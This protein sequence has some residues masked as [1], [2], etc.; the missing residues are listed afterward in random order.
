MDPRGKVA[1]ITGGSSGIG[2]AT[3]IALAQAGASVV[4]ADIDD[5]GGR[6]TVRLIEEGGGR[7]AFVHADV[8]RGE[9]LEGMVAYAEETF[10]GLDILHNNAGIAT[11]RPRF[12]DASPVRWEQTF[13]VNL[14][15]VIAGTQV[16]VPAMRRRGGGVIVNTASIAGLTTYLPDPVYAA[17]KH[18]VVG[19]T[20]ALA[21][22]R[23]EA[24]IRVNCLCP[25]VVDTPLL[26]KGFEGLTPEERA[27]RQAIMAQM[28]LIAPSEVA[29]AVLEFVRDDSLAG[30]AMGIIYG[31]PR[32]LIP[33]SIT[34]RGDPAQRV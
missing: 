16:A 17:S 31:R 23:D 10:G 25:G 22:L 8:T 27:Q 1:L 9:D 33:P 21:F 34:L 14:W 19:L 20:R 15:A 30:E 28:P 6:E 4:V 2:R 5:E 3:A 24:N 29:E 13:A 12:P 18:G 26:T 11:G 7:A 32:R